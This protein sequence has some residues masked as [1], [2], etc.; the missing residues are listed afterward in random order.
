MNDILNIVIPMAGRGSRFA[1]DGWEDPKPLIKLRHKRMIEVVVDN[2]RPQRP[3]RFIF[4]CLR[5]HLEFYNLT[6]ILGDAA[7]GCAIIA[8]DHITAGAACSVLAAQALIDNEQPLMIANSDQWVDVNVNDYLCAY[9]QQGS[10]GFIMTMH[11]DDPKWSYAVRDEQGRVTGVFEKQVA[12]PEAT[13][14]IY[15]FRRGRDF[16]HHAQAMIAA[17]ET[18]CGDYYVAPVYTRWYRAERAFIETYNIGPLSTRM[19]GLG[20]PEDLTYFLT[21]PQCEKATGA[22]RD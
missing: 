1:I 5:V 7:P 14:G 3:H 12:S 20:T 11:A 9:D 22:W 8:L 15:N 10:D 16:C 17:G 21:L 18:S 4:V 2:L 19:F 13:V 6:E